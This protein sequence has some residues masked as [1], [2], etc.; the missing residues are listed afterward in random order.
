ML[1]AGA[2]KAS[3]P[4]LAVLLQLLRLTFIASNAF[5]DLLTHEIHDYKQRLG[6]IQRALS[7][8]AK[9]KTLHNVFMVS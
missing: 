1:G 5:P 4:L 3:H 7:S 8:S 6:N 9:K 2:V